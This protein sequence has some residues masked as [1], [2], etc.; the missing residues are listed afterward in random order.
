MPLYL[1]AS[2]P[3]DGWTRIIR[4]IMERGMLR[5]DERGI[6]TR[7]CDNVLIHVADPYTDRVSPKYPFS[8]RVLREKYATQLLN[9]D[10]MDFQ[11]TYGER[12]N[13]WGSEMIDQLD[14]VVRKLKETPN[15]RRAVASTWDPRKDTK[16]D[17]VP[18][19]NHFVF[20]EREG[21]LDLSVTI[22]SNDMYGAW[23]ANVYALAELL[24][25]ISERTGIR[26][27]TITT[28][29]VNAHVYSHDW[30]KAHEVYRS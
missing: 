18:C 10:R 11:Y 23:L 2:T 21:L 8:E 17:E 3:V 27:G 20:M 14:Y 1:K 15:T 24:S 6:E 29:S 30:D 22:R 9:P 5:Q 13:A 19:L 26:R 28:F 12:L 4:K 7:W 16:V 25:S